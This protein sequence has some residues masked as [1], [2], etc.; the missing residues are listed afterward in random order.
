MKK[1]LYFLA[2]LAL[3]AVTSC[4]PDN[5]PEDEKPVDYKA[6]V[7]GEWHCAP[8]EFNADIYVAFNENGSFDLYQKIG[9]GRHRHYSGKWNA[10][11]SILSGTYSDGS[12]WGSTY[13][14]VFNDDDTLV[15]TALSDEAMTYTRKSIPSDVKENSIDVKSA[16]ED[17]YC[18]VF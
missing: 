4:K 3:V 15:L 11:D 17:D 5:K 7:I 10:Q 18:P 12:P 8:A 13:Q 1:I 14:M 9:D 2:A 6:L 16:D